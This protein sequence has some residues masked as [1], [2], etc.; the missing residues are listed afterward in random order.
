MSR[1]GLSI[2][3]AVL[4]SMCCVA[5]GDA[6]NKQQV[7]DAAVVRSYVP[8]YAK[9]FSIDYLA[10]STRRIALFNLDTPGDTLQV[11]RWKPRSIDAIACLSTTHIAFIQAMGRMDDLKGAGF[12]D[13]LMDTLAQQR[14]ADGRLVNLTSG[15]EL[16]PEAVFQV[17]PQLLFVYPFGGPSYAKFLQKG[18]GCVQISEYAERHPLGRAEWLHVFGVLLGEEQK[19]DSIFSGIELSYLNLRDSI[20]AAGEFKPKV[21]TGSMD[22]DRWAVPSANSFMATLIEDAGGE[23]LFSDTSSTGNL[24]L[25]FE[26]FL[27]EAGKADFWGKIIYE[28]NPNSADVII[29]GDER[30]RSLKSFSDR[31]VFYCNALLT[32]YHGQAILEPHV[33]LRDIHAIVHPS[34]TNTATGAYFKPWTIYE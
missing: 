8:Q 30:L 13:R 33:L 4:L 10:D 11:I 32:D 17:M 14:F 3:S 7:A 19:A 34:A 22:G 23:Y 18:I 24:V 28:A 31:H 6:H 20:A 27:T 21:F 29:N 12:A 5:C 26:T 25:P 15:N 9:G 16:N 1:W 2:W